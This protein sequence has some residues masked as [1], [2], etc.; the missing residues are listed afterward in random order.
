MTA[1]E[2]RQAG[3]RINNLK[4]FF[5]I[6]EGWRC[7]DD[8]LPRGVLT[9]ALPTGMV[10]GSSLT[11]A[12]LDLMIQGYYAARGWTA[13]GHIPELKLRELKLLEIMASP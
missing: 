13:E 5:N 3:E 11:Q 8:T 10:Q 7:A 4:K 9:E 2:L 6:R 1:E 12:D